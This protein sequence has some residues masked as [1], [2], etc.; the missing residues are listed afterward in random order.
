M[1]QKSKG[2][3]KGD[4]FASALFSM[5]LGENPMNKSFKKQLL[6]LK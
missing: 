3:I 4:D 1:D 2:I 6:G 5:W